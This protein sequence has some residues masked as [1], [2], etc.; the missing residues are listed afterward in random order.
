MRVHVFVCGEGEDQLE[1]ECQLESPPV[2][3]FLSLKR[4]PYF[5]IRRSP[6]KK[7]MVKPRTTVLARAVNNLADRSLRKSTVECDGSHRETTGSRRLTHRFC[8]NWIPTSVEAH[9]V[10]RRRGSQIF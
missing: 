6:E 1:S 10:V 3:L 4:R 7:N 5:K 9:R 2:V 8:S